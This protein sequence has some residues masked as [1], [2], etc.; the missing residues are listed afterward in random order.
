MG[1]SNLEEVHTCHLEEVL[2]QNP[3]SWDVHLGGE[4][5]GYTCY[6]EEVYLVH[7]IE[8]PLRSHTYHLE[9]KGAY[10]LRIICGATSL[11]ED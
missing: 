6:F 1:N 3:I 5:G 11:I 4:L 8:E 7:L 2:D 10:L 9:V